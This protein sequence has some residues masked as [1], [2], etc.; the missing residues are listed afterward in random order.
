RPDVITI[1]AGYNDAAFLMDEN[2]LERVLRWAHEHFAIYVALKRLVSALGGP[3]MHS[4]WSMYLS[5]ASRDYVQ[6]Q[7]ELHVARYE[8]NVRTIV[9]L[10]RQDGA[11]VF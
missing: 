5:S 6:R 9:S 2:T 8:R 1:Y 3:E 4:R 7:I 11:L 10:A